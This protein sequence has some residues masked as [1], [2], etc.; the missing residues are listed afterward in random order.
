MGYSYI[1]HLLMSRNEGNPFHIA[2]N[3]N[4]Y[5]YP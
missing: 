1:G 3:Y 4:L 2:M 5:S